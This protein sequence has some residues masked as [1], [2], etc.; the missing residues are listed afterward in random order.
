MKYIT[1]TSSTSSG[2]LQK[3]AAAVATVALAGAVL[4]F[5]SVF[6]AVVLVAGVIGWAYL[7]WKT[8]HVRKIMRDLQAGGDR[9][10]DAF[11][12]S[13]FQQAP[14][15]RE[16]FSGQEFSRQEKFEG[17]VIEGEAVRVNERG[18]KTKP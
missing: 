3:A 1:Y 16:K 10:R 11:E 6:L 14:F 12:A 15:S 2:P 8:R 5:S 7:W 18:N 13:G 9:A 17:V 4:V